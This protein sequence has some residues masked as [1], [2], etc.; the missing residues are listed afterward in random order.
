M[1]QFVKLVKMM[2]D[3]GVRKF[4]GETNNVQADRWL[5]NLE[6]HFE[7]SECPVEYRRRIA[8]NLLEEDAGAWWD[9]VASRYRCLPISW[10]TFKKEFELKSFPLESRDR[11]EKQFIGLEQGERSV[12]DYGQV[13]TRLQKYFYNGNGDEASIVRRFLKG[14]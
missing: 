14:L 5:R 2:R 12:R 13:F 1:G 4:K 3:L 7:T 8:V 6:M 11:L 9:T 10:E